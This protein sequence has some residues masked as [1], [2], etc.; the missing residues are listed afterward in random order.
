MR[1]WQ[2]S[3][4]DST[5]SPVAAFLASFTLPILP[6]PMVLPRDHCPVWGAEMVVRRLVVVDEDPTGAA[7]RALSV[8]TPL[9]GI[10]V[11]AD[12]SDAYRAWLD[13]GWWLLRVESV[14][15]G[16]GAA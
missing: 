2:G 7:E 14:R 12:A 10:A 16:V 4:Y 3:R 5:C 6:A 8:A 15:E 11:V 13:R 1:A 9:M